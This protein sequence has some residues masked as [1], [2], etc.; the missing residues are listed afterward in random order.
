MQLTKT[1]LGLIIGCLFAAGMITLLANS[2]IV[3]E[4]T[5]ATY[6]DFGT[7]AGRLIAIQ[8]LPPDEF[9]RQLLAYRKR[10]EDE[11]AGKGGLVPLN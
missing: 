10:L 2:Q 5:S 11:A 8:Q 3:N 1:T 9:D 7:P 4:R 6:Y